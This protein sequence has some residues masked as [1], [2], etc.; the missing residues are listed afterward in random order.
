[1]TVHSVL[2]LVSVVCTRLP[3]LFQVKHF[4]LDLNLS[5]LSL[6]L[7]G[8]LHCAALHA[9]FDQQ[10]F[11]LFL[12]CADFHSTTLSELQRPTKDCGALS[13]NMFHDPEI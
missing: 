3:S 9:D 8:H 4:W 10:L 2:L 11:L 12:N 7:C 13:S 6:I 1:M 5:S